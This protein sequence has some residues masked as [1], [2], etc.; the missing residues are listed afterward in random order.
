M[1]FDMKYKY[2]DIIR[3]IA[4]IAVL[5]YHFGIL[6]GG[7]LAVCIFF[8]L[9]GYLSCVSA[10]KKDFSIISYYLNRLLKIYL[11]LLIVVFLSIFAISFFQD[12]NWINL[13]PETTSVL[14]GYNNIWQ[15][16]AN[17]DYFARHI[18]SPFIHL[19]YISIML[20]F[21]LIFPFL[22]I[23]LK[24]IG[25][26]INK[27]VPCF[28]T[29]ILAIFSYIYFCKLN[30]DGN[31]MMA[32]YN[33]FSRVFSLFFGMFLGFVQIYHQPSKSKIDNRI[34]FSI[35][36]LILI[37]L[38]VFIDAKS[39]FLMISMLLTTIISCKLII[40]SINVKNKKTIFDKVIDFL[41]NISY[42][43]YLVQYPIIFIFQYISISAYIKIPVILLL[44]IFVSFI[45]KFC[46]NKNS[47]PKFL[48]Y[49]LCLVMMFI[50]LYGE[51]KYFQAK[52]HTSEMKILEQ[53]L[54]ENE[55]MMQDMQ[56]KYEANFKE[57]EDNWSSVFEDLENEEVGL[58]NVVTNL[59]IIGIGD[60]VMLG[61]I[62]HLYQK[63]PNGYFDAQISRTAWMANGI[64]TKLKSNNMLGNVVVLN[65]GSNGDCPEWCKKEIMDTIGNRKVF[66]INTTN[67][68]YVN[69]ELISLSK[70]YDNL[71][72][73]DWK[74]ISKNHPEYFIADKI[75][76]TAKGKEVYAKVI[77]DS[78][79]EVYLE[80]YNI[81]KENLMNKYEEEYK[82]KI[83]FYGNDILI[84]AYANLKEDFNNSSFIIDK[85]YSYEILRQKVEDSILKNSL[86][87]NVVFAFDSTLQLTELQYL[88][89]IKLCENHNIYILDINNNVNNMKLENVKIINFYD[90][91][92]NNSDYL[93]VDKIH[94]T[95]KGNQALYELIKR[96]LTFNNQ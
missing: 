26:K 78:I 68:N 53:Q 44:I 1:K 8:V 95:E 33:T 55:K 96:S 59:N 70:K 5:F 23:G 14:L 36:Y 58:E 94:L 21:E 66:W 92:I 3:V 37:I 61:A 6:K 2:I 72:I 32:Y 87:Y 24:K 17:L 48:K 52:D 63:F 69:N 79:Y 27:N 84:N 50:F 57:N 4:C 35:Y 11:P 10:S 40:Y 43:I 64:L 31:I 25:D 82:N 56:A 67:Y 54:S 91:L 13:K 12:I 19:W 71:Y 85:N 62:D 15:L 9:S 39:N 38:F 28:I 46:I 29:L 16:N 20:Q 18:D 83:T 41:S 76:L 75:H 86:N 81:K 73:I 49:I 51:I 80:E 74:N 90:D 65:L 45:L 34:L 77:Y 60:S 22:Y 88:E 42:E 89:L 30:M 47:R 93:M 7:Y